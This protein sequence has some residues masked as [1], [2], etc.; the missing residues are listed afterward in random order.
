M[1]D[2]GHAVQSVFTASRGD[3]AMT[4]WDNP[5]EKPASRLKMHVNLVF[6]LVA[7]LYRLFSDPSLLFFITSF[8]CALAGIGLYELARLRWGDGWWSTMPAL[9]YY[10]SPRVHDANMFGFKPITIAAACAVWA[11]WA[12]EKRKDRLGWALL[13]LILLCQED[14]AAIVPMIGLF[15]IWRGDRKQ[16][17]AMIGLGLAYL[18]FIFWFL[19]PAVSPGGFVGIGN[20]YIGDSP[21]NTS[22]FVEMAG[23]AFRPDRLRS[24]LYFLLSGAIVAFKGW[25]GFLVGLPAMVGALVA[26]PSVPARITGTY[27]WPPVVAATMIACIFSY[28]PGKQKKAMAYVVGATAVF[29]V[30]FTPL[31]YGLGMSSANYRTPDFKALEEIAR[32]IPPDATISA[33][34]NLGP[35]LANRKVIASFPWLVNQADYVI[36]QPHAPMGPQSGILV[37]TDW[38]VVNPWFDNLFL[39]R[40]KAIAR[41]PEWELVKQKNHIYVFK[42]RKTPAPPKKEDGDKFEREVYSMTWEMSLNHAYWWDINYY[43][44]DGY[45]WKELSDHLSKKSAA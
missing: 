16:G 34:N 24:V 5:D 36:L 8:A 10:L 32:E 19:V 9:A 42:R 20:R 44:N 6:L 29:S 7:P 13:V 14:Q 30:F 2:F 35:T 37:G 43:L 18:A 31:P 26:K 38:A 21:K 1:I 3:L 27:Y 40:I 22:T 15:R 25:P 45:D 28:A 41:S 11:I 23:R 4:H 12:F 17:L 39:D 33:Q